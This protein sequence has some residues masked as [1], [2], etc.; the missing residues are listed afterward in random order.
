MD[1]HERVGLA[2][3]VADVFKNRGTSGG[4]GGG[5]TPVIEDE[6]PP[7]IRAAV[8]QAEASRGKGVD[9]FLH[10]RS[11]HGLRGINRDPVMENMLGMPSVTQQNGLSK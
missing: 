5:N 2:H 1:L 8:G 11:F 7:D 4:G 9:V 6:L 3:R 10:T